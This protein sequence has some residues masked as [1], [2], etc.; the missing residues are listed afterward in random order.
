MRDRQE[1]EKT[2]L[3]NGI[4]VYTYQLDSPIAS[5][6]IQLPVG[7]AH[8]Y[9]GNGFLNGSV[10]FL[11]HLQLIRSRNFPKPH[12]LNREI[13]LLG[14]HFK[15][16]IFR[17]KTTYAIDL[18]TSELDFASKA[19]VER[20]YHPLFNQEDIER[21]RS[22]IANERDKERF[23]PGRSRASQ[24]YDTE[25]IFDM[26]Y[27]QDQL[28]GSNDDLNAMSAERF[29]DMHSVISKDQETVAIA[30]G[31][32]DFSLLKEELSKIQTAPTQLTRKLNDARWADPK[33]RYVSFDTVSRPTLEVAWIYP[34]VNQ[35]ERVSISFILSLLTNH[36]H[37]SLYQ[38]L[39][40]QKGWVYSIDH[41][42][43]SHRQTLFGMSFPLNTIKQVEY[44]RGILHDR[45]MDAINNQEMVEQEIRRRLNNQVYNY[46]TASSIMNQ[47]STYL[48]GNKK[49]LTEKEW[50]EAIEAMANPAWRLEIVNRFFKPEEMGEI[51]FT[52]A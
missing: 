31:N 24:Y 12:Q 52:P 23:Y 9:G 29:T 21:E 32:N 28:Y 38:E 34:R 33:F 15:G 5:L 41:F 43:T 25:F 37:G 46:Q 47:A 35:R 16:N 13:G 50:K 42:M 7:A 36:V 22:V 27:K 4:T 30:V 3:D 40:Q 45:I 51:G 6:E 44:V 14:G 1:F 26:P 19:L 18:P 10:H 20:V 8:S 11:E 2:V 39:R 49:I 48:I 17:S